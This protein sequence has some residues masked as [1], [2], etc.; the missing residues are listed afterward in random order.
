MLFCLSMNSKLQN[1]Y[2]YIFFFLMSKKPI[3]LRKLAP[4]EQVA[5]YEDK[6]RWRKGIFSLK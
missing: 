5:E 4:L 2:I 3:S 6:Q 1:I